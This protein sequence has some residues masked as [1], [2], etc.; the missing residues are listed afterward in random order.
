MKKHNIEKTLR[1]FPS[2]FDCISKHLVCERSTLGGIVIH[3][4]WHNV[5]KIPHI[6]VARGHVDDDD[7]GGR[8]VIKNKLRWTNERHTEIW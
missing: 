8:Y 3:V 2:Y 1:L 6:D 5:K 7:G 4:T